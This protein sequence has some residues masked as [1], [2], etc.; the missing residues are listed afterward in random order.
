[1]VTV[2]CSNHNLIAALGTEYSAILERRKAYNNSV[3]LEV[4]GNMGKD[5]KHRIA[6]KKTPEKDKRKVLK[7]SGLHKLVNSYTPQDLRSLVI[8]QSWVRMRIA[9]KLYRN[10]SKRTTNAKN[11]EYRI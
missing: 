11:P 1:M 5:E 4:T 8:C 6:V 9:R 3:T 7:N 10:I 2:G